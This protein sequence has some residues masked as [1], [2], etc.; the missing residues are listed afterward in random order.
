MGKLK[1]ILAK[2]EPDR[3]Q[4]LEELDATSVVEVY[5]P[6]A[7]KVRFEGKIVSVSKGKNGFP[8]R[9]AAWLMDEHPEVSDDAP[10]SGSKKE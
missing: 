10:A 1:E 8:A 2:P 7:F 4:A 6:E 3:S 9:F 5:S